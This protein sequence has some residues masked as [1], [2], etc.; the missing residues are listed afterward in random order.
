M[1]TLANF[2]RQKEQEEEREKGWHTKDIPFRHS[3]LQP[4][5]FAAITVITMYSKAPESEKEKLFTIV[6]AN[7]AI[8]ALPLAEAIVR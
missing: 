8:F 2:G 5:K 1:E 7:P 4:N 6:N 3:Q